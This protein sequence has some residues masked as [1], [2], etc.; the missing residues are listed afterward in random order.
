MRALNPL[1]EQDAALLLAVNG[2]EFTLAGFR[3][4]D[5]RG[6]LYPAS[7]KRTPSEQQR[8][9]AAV[10]RLLR[11]LRGHGLIKKVNKTNRYLLTERGR[12]AIPA[13]L[14]ARQAD[15]AKLTN[16]A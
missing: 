10:T 3:N 9:S 5:V 13:L 16:A 15:T 11:L 8:Q 14:A 12:H 7:A 2:G 1:G 4:K 6:L